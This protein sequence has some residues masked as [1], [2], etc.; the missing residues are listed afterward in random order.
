MAVRWG[1]AGEAA[2]GPG[3]EPVAMATILVL[4]T[5]LYFLSCGL[6]LVGMGPG[7]PLA[8]QF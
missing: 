2:A 6:E 5:T 1:R 4:G 3:K 8:L 7:K